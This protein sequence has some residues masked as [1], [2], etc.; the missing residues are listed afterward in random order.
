M[1]FSAGNVE[2]LHNGQWG[3]VCDDEWDEAE[4]RV[5]C[6]QLGFSSK[7]KHKATHSAAFGVARRMYVVLFCNKTQHLMQKLMG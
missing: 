2:V 3:A 5:V 4:A 6:R 1:L 7:G